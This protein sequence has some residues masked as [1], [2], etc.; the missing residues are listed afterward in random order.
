MVGELIFELFGVV[1]LLCYPFDL[2]R[3]T[4]LAPPVGPLP[5]ST[6]LDAPRILHARRP[7]RGRS[8]NSSE[9]FLFHQDEP[10]AE[11]LR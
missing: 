8:Q 9:M 2:L 6:V 11:R 1:A 10:T 3:P 7:T 5:S 4:R